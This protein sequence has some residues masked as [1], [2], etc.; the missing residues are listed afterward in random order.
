VC[1]EKLNKMGITSSGNALHIEHYTA[2]VK[3]RFNNKKTF[4][5]QEGRGK[6]SWGKK[7]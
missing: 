4:L 1:G 5:F 6:F 2:G 7:V 3:L